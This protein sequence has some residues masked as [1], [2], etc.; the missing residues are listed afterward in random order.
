MIKVPEKIKPLYEKLARK[1][2]LEVEPLNIRGRTIQIIKPSNIEDF[3]TD[4]GLKVEN[5]PFW[6]K[7]WEASLVLADFMASVKPQGRVLELGAGLG[8]VG[9]TAAAFGHE[10]T[11]TDYEDECLDFLRLNAAYNRLENVTVERLDWREPK[12]LGQFQI[13]VGAEIVFSGRLFEPLFEIFRKYLAPGGVIYLA[14]DKERMRTLAPFLYLAE[15][16]YEQAVSQRKLRADDETHEIV[17][18]RLIP[19]HPTWDT[20]NQA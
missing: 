12:E 14:H 7:I 13:I 15:K 8:V 20:Q 6:L 5:F 11:L 4:E 17:I 18:S 1:Y 3:L 9:L 2:R 19:R 16:E 10:V